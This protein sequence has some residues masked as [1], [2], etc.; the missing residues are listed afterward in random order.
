MVILLGY[1]TTSRAYCVYNIRTRSVEESINVMVDDLKATYEQGSLPVV[2]SD[3]EN[4]SPS[5]VKIEKSQ[6]NQEE[7]SSKSSS[8]EEVEKIQLQPKNKR[9]TK[10]LLQENIIGDP[11]I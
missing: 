11:N 2:L 5:Q 7:H 4:E 3:H 1:S 8:E 6:G 10:G 9:L